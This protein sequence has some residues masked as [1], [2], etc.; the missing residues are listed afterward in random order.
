[1]EGG[2]NG[3]EQYGIATIEKHAFDI[4][5]KMLGSEGNEASLGKGII[6]EIGRRNGRLD[7]A[8]ELR[9]QYDKP[10]DEPPW[11]PGVPPHYTADKVV[12]EYA[13]K[14]REQQEQYDKPK[15]SLSEEDNT[16]PFYMPYILDPFR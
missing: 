12:F 11:E 14:R 7:Y 4:A 13:K 3:M 15:L 2:K 10:P 1:M 16:A 9:E 8:K 6:V 5:K